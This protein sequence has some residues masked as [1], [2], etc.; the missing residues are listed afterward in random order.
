MSRIRALPHLFHHEVNIPTLATNFI[1]LILE[2]FLYLI[3]S[4]RL[5]HINKTTTSH[6]SL[7]TTEDDILW[8]HKEE[9]K[10]EDLHNSG[11]LYRLALSCRP[12]DLPPPSAR[13]NPPLG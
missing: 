12:P 2:H 7:S 5:Q 1:T 11:L 6:F 4:P 3:L 10:E 9:D 8:V 13:C